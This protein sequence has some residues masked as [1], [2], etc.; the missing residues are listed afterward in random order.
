MLSKATF[1]IILIGMPGSG[2]STV[3][4]DLAKRLSYG[5]VDTDDLI[6]ENEG[7]SLQHIIDMRGCE[8]LRKIEEDTLCNLIRH[9]HIIATGG[10][11]VYS[12][13]AMNYLKQN[14]LVVF[15][16]VDLPKLKE[17]IEDYDKR[18]IVKRPDQDLE[19]LYEKRHALYRKYSDITIE[20][21]RLADN[22]ILDEIIEEIKKN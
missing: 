11:A 15:L 6:R 1:N 16:D 21:S 8:A 22:E 20:C 5:F 13:R 2:K 9:N 14:G 7:C 3:G 17:R 19:D 18:G 10:S 4:E 12:Q